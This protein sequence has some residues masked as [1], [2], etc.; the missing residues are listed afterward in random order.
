MVWTGGAWA[1]GP[2]GCSTGVPTL[3]MSAIGTSTVTVSFFGS[4]ASISV[5]GR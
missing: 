2:L 5:T 3:A 1:A 4:R